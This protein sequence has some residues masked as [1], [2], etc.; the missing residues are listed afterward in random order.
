LRLILLAESKAASVPG[1]Y[2]QPPRL[3]TGK[4]KYYET[5]KIVQ[6]S[7]PKGFKFKSYQVLAS[8]R[9]A[10][11]PGINVQVI[12]SIST[13]LRGSP[14]PSHPNDRM[15]FVLFKDAV[16]HDYNILVTSERGR[17]STQPSPSQ[18]WRPRSHV[19]VG[20]PCHHH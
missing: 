4:P 6:A 8:L 16:V 9:P 17:P 10:A 5:G 20:R 12:A 13:L 19:L 15:S 18:T 2:G 3:Q 14:I 7:K 11:N 1:S